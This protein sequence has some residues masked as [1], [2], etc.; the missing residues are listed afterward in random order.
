MA[1][2]AIFHSR[3][4]VKTDFLKSE[5]LIDPDTRYGEPGTW[6]NCQDKLL[7]TACI[8]AITQVVDNLFAGNDP[9]TGTWRVDI[10]MVTTRHGA[11]AADAIAPTFIE[12]A[13]AAT[14]LDDVV[15]GLIAAADT[16]AGLTSLDDVAAWNRF[17][18]LASLSVGGTAE[19]LRATAVASG[20]EFTLVVT[21]PAGNTSTPTIVAAPSTSTVKVGL[22]VEI[23]RT[24][25]S[26]GF[27]EF[28]N[29]FIKQMTS[30]TTLADIIGPVYLGVDTEPVQQGFSFREYSEGKTAAVAAYGVMLAYG[31]GAVSGVGQPI[32]IRNTTSGD[33]IPGLVTD[34]AG[35]AAG[36]TANLWTMTPVVVIN[37]LYLLQIVFGSVTIVLTH[38]SS[39]VATATTISDGMRAQ[40]A[41]Y[42]G[43]D[44]PLEGIVG[45]GTTTFIATGP[46]DGRS[47]TPSNVGVGDMGP[48]ETEAAVATHIL[49]TRGD[50]FDAPST[51]IGAVPV[52]VPHSNA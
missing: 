14:D 3:D 35:A 34:A 15:L 12:F 2:P 45:S 36:A 40:L 10:T 4:P 16:G 46:A 30:G 51:R 38:L 28:G 50:K 25:G 18:S 23:D 20:T 49:F 27:D 13:A 9:S 24:Q 22:Y 21:P 7:C 39:G 44:Q 19:T 17:K 48:V 43:A 41:L 32:Y 26:N 47:F 37:T 31:E 5:G 33:F 11:A 52:N 8:A 1:I 29:V 6:H 42:N